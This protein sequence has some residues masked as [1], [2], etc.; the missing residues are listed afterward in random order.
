MGYEKID[1]R[2][3]NVIRAHVNY[4]YLREINLEFNDD[5]IEIQLAFGSTQK[6]STQMISYIDNIDI[7]DDHI[8]R[9]HPT[10]HLQSK[11]GKN[12]GKS[13]LNFNNDLNKFISFFKTNLAFIKQKNFMK[14]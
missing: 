10:F 13:Y 2:K 4:V 5:L 7:K 1:K 8:T 14:Q 3:W 12:I 9:C 11:W 6:S